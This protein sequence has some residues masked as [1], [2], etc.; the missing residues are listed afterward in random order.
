MAMGNPLGPI[1]ADIFL[2]CY[3]DKLLIVLMTLKRFFIAVTLMK[4]LQFFV[5]L[6]ILQFFSIT[7]MINKNL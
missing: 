5:K 7:L 4:R 2:G 3:E 1:F 6:L